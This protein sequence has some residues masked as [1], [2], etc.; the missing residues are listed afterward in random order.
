ME[1]DEHGLLKCLLIKLSERLIGS[2]CIMCSFLNSERPGL[3]LELGCDGWLEQLV[4]WQVE[5]L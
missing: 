2:V 5:K 1:E 4:P 3:L